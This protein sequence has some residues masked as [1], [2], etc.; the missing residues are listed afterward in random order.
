MPSLDQHQSS[1][2]TKM[3]LIGDSGAGKT[4]ATA[5]LAAA[6]FKLRYADTDNGLDL[7]VDLLKNPASPYVKAAIAKGQDPKKLLSE[8]QYETITDPMKSV[9][10]KLIPAQATVWQRL[11]A[12]L[13]NWDPKTTG[14][15]PNKKPPAGQNDTAALG[16]ISTW[17]DDT[18]LVLDSLSRISNAALN[19]VL[20]MNARLGQQPHQSDYFTAQTMVEGLLQMLYDSNIRCNVI[21]IAH[22]AFIGDDS[23]GV[24]HGYPASVGKA[25]PPKIGQYF[26]TCLMVKTTGIGANQKRKIL[27]RT[28]GLVELKNSAPMKVKPEYDLENGLAEYFR[29]VRGGA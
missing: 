12:L 11:M 8:I 16:P 17:G 21:M 20:S 2:T 18:I 25:L 14:N 6:G 4:G 13:D 3:L 26:N 10:G 5:S 9:G 24:Q 29:D 27:T 22:I 15:W 19:L 28:T 1:G 23:T 7:L